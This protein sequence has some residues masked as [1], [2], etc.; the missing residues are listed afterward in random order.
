LKYF[1][2]LLLPIFLSANLT[3]VN[4]HNKEIAL[5]ESFDIESSFLYDRIMNDMR[6]KN[7]SKYRDKHFFR[8]MDEAYLF[9]PFIKNILTEYG[10]PA[11][12]LYLAMA[13]SNFSNRAYSKKDASGLWQFIPGTA[14]LYGLKIDEY[15]DE[16]RDLV[17]STRAAAKYLSNLHERFG[18]WYLAAIAYNCGGGRLN[19]A[20]KKAG[21]D[22]LNVLL[23][24]KKRYIPRE[25]RLYIRKIIA[26]AL[27]GNDEEFLLNSE[28]GHLL[29]RANAYSV[30]TVKLASGASLKRLSKLVG[31]PL[32]ELKKLNRHL[33]YD[34]VPPY[35][36]EYNIY[37]PYIKLT[38]FK[39]KYY[40]DKMKN[41]YKVHIVR[42]GD[43]LSKIGV[44]YG[45]SYKI[46]MDFNGLKNSRLSLNQKLIIPIESRIK[47]KKINSKS[48]YMVRKGDTLDSI[49]RAYKVSV[50]NIKLQNHLSGSL[51]KIGERLK[52]N[53]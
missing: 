31:I 19:H 45:V 34:F 25:S 52:I 32:G 20:I 1:L 53:E 5:L 44:K 27:V 17:K 51:I 48:Y 7:S 47:N 46:V 12:F 39:Q 13:E 43:N 29:N 22:D 3:Y 37:I 14:K 33:K 41:I 36:E 2:L 10:I 18:K 11:Q 28:Y 40:E 15:V 38:D 49:A 9:I 30:S 16:R 35:Q 42:S 23:D 6:A 21:T 8:A 50:H 24:P 4:S 26:L